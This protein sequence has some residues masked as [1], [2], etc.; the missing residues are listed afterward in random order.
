MKV[1]ELTRVSRAEAGGRWDELVKQSPDGWLFATSEWSSLVT[2]VTDWQLSDVG[3]AIE[4]QGSLLGVLP[5]HFDAANKRLA[6]CGWGGSGPVIRADLG[7]SRRLSLA[8]HLLNQARRT[9]LELGA[10]EITWVHPAA[11]RATIE[12][13]G[14][15][16]WFDLD[17]PTTYRAHAVVD[18]TRN[19][20]EGTKY[21]S[22]SARQAAGIALA[23]RYAVREEPW[24]ENLTAYYDVH[25]ET[26]SRTG[27]QPHP[28]EYFQ[29]ISRLASEQNSH[30]LFVARDEDGQAVAF[31][32]SAIFQ[33]SG[34][35]HTGCS[36]ARAETDGANY[37]LFVTVLRELSESGIVRYDCGP[38]LPRQSEETKAKGISTFK[39]KF[40]GS[41]SMTHEIRF[42]LHSTESQTQTQYGI[43]TRHQP[44]PAVVQR[45]KHLTWRRWP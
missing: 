40:G 4:S 22:Q 14:V 8:G 2:N 18:L 33:D 34:M 42:P 41:L 3:F 15:S 39:R 38:I 17:L 30:R 26:Y 24:S 43:S 13:K 36:T 12:S 5:L 21:V 29:G 35:Y 44:I 19:C 10:T 23:R 16:P 20:V 32:N 28:F 6:S 27:V 1:E 9:G 31:H 45:L 37:L 7:E 11:S 25:R